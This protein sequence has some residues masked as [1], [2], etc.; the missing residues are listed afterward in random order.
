MPSLA[1]ACGAHGNDMFRLL[2]ET[3]V[4]G[5]M[6]VFVIRCSRDTVNTFKDHL[7]KFRANQ[8]VLYDYKSDLHGIGNCR[9]IM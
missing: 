7:D 4:C 6:H 5:I 2:C 3:A 8:D 1:H 9:I